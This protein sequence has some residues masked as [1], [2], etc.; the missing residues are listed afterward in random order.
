ML[1]V[2]VIITRFSVFSSLSPIVLFV[3]I[4]TDT[5]IAISVCDDQMYM[6][7]M[8]LL[9]KIIGGLKIRVD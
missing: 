6:L 3:K 1:L 8:Q 5:A 2:Y 4:E 7:F 9:D